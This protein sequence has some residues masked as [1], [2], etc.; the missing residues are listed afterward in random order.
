MANEYVTKYYT[1]SVTTN[2]MEI[3]LDAY[4]ASKY[5]KYEFICGDDTSGQITDSEYVFFNLTSGEEYLV[6][7]KV[8]D[9]DGVGISAGDIYVTMPYITLTSKNPTTTTISITYDSEYVSPNQMIFYCE[10]K[11]NSQGTQE[12]N[13]S[14][15]SGSI[16]KFTGLSPGHTYEIWVEAF[17]NGSNWV[18][19]SIT[20]TTLSVTSSEYTITDVTYDEV[21]KSTYVTFIYNDGNARIPYGYYEIYA[22]DECVRYF[23]VTSND[24]PSY[25]MVISCDISTP[26][27]YEI[28]IKKYSSIEDFEVDSI[29]PTYE[30]TI[31]GLSGPFEW[32]E[33]KVQGDPFNLTAKEWN[34]LTKTINEIRDS[35]FLDSWGFTTVK[36]E[37]N[38]YTKDQST[39]FTAAIYKEVVDAINDIPGYSNSLSYVDPGDP[40]TAGCLNDLK[41]IVNEIIENG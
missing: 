28:Y 17:I 27:R 37:S 23:S 3:K 5:V 12:I 16:V 18:S 8:Y 40:V 21:N 35:K 4:I 41:D 38:G 7:V 33:P 30:F 24:E 15:L 26:G 13:G 39:K 19:D 6:R 29:S 14:T 10:D 11:S 31:T 22:N 25:E 20:E 34:K 32:D 1:V 9:S 2:A 36:G